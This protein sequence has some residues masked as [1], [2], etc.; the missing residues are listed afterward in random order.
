MQTPQA[1][2]TN[3]IIAGVGAS[4]ARVRTAEYVVADVD[5]QQ[6]WHLL[7]FALK[8]EEAWPV[9]RALVVALAPKLELAGCREDWIPY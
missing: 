5:R 4:L 7:S 6:A 8:V 2:F 9:T 3:Y 1:L